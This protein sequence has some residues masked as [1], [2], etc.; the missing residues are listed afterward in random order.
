MARVEFDGKEQRLIAKADALEAKAKALREEAFAKRDAR[1][2]KRPAIDRLVFAASSRCCCGHGMA[3]DP[4]GVLGADD[5]P[6]KRPSQWDCSAILLGIADPVHYH[7][8]PMPFAFYEVKSENQPSA[9]GH[10]TRTPAEPHPRA[11]IK[12]EKAA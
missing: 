5:G 10:T 6:F 1:D 2:L 8:A 12:P 3:Y 7:D 4:T 11:F 9:G